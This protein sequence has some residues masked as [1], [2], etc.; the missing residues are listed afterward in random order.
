MNG[1]RPIA[2][3]PFMAP[4]WLRCALVWATC[5]ACGASPRTSSTSPG[6]APASAAAAAQRSAEDLLE[7]A[8]TATGGRQAKRAL[9]A[10]RGRGQARLLQLGVTGEVDWLWAAPRQMKTTLTLGRLGTV[11]SGT[12]G[13]V[14]W[15]QAP[16]Q[17]A[18][19]LVGAE[20][21]R[22]LR[23]ATF[24]GELDWKALYAKVERAGETKGETKIDGEEVDTVVAT[25]SDGQSVTWHFSR[26]THLL[27]ASE[28]EMEG[29]AGRVRARTRFF[30]YRPVG[31]VRLPFRTT[32][33]QGPVTIELTFEQLEAN[34]PLPDDAFS[35][36][37]ALGP[38]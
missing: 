4:S 24:H 2:S 28:A 12:D 37:A 31:A 30:D 13:E 34:P 29:P 18:R 26:A 25:A 20:A 19:R 10:L 5:A 7:A 22:R 6:S 11:A 23:E 9:V 1:A 21:A 32:I 35:P 38:R 27:L 8:I 33:E 16:L 14:V 3:P 36:P 17:G 15:E